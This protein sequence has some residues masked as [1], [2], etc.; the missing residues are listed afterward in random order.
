MVG[1]MSLINNGT[2]CQVRSTQLKIG[3]VRTAPSGK[4]RKSLGMLPHFKMLMC[5][6]NSTV[7]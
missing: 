4:N 6:D 5:G 3:Q 7:A 1:R 2:G